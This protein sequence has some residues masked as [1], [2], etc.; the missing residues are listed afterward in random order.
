MML[1]SKW[2]RRNLA[3][4]VGNRVLDDRVLRAIAEVSKHEFVPIEV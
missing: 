3:A 4:E 2:S 1:R